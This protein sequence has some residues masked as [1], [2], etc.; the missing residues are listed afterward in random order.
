LKQAQKNA[1]KVRCNSSP[2]SADKLQIGWL[3]GEIEQAAEDIRLSN[4]KID[5]TK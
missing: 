3:G 5:N 1:E 4:F 2:L